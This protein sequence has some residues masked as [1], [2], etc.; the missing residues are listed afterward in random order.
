M[1]QY[2]KGTSSPTPLP[3]NQVPVA[4]A[5]ADQSIA[6]PAS[7]VTLNGLG[8]DADGS[9]VSY[10]WTKQAGPTS[11]TLSN[12]S[13]PN[14]KVNNLVHGTYTFRLTVKDNSGNTGYDEVNIVVK[15]SAVTIPPPSTTSKKIR[16]N[17][18]GGANPYN[19]T[20][21]NNW[22]VGI[23]K[24][25]VSQA[26][27]YDDGS[28]SVVKATL[29]QSTGIG[30]NSSSIPAGMA[31]S[32]VLRYTSYSTVAR[33]LKLSGFSTSKR[34]DIELFASRNS[35]SGNRTVFAV[36]KAKDTVSTYNNSIEK[37][38]LANLGPDANGQIVININRL[39]T[40]TY[41][42]GFI[43]TERENAT[44]TTEASQ[45]I[46]SAIET[47]VSLNVFPN[48]VEDR[49]VVQV[50]NSFIGLMNVEIVDLKGVVIKTFSLSKSSEGPTQAYLSLAGL[51]KG[52]YI[53]NVRMSQWS[54]SKIIFKQ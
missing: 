40:Y 43:I 39:Q 8:T 49:L 15:P 17:I 14:P 30:D 23:G 33:T 52:E 34:Y 22:N 26:F 2:S 11:F 7:S 25:I 10:T 35:S 27:K 13:I 3:V 1:L 12:A 45:R 32:E 36:S 4:K 46:I 42:N 53:V 28:A 44:T 50:K 41:L 18:F 5:G 6:L 24:A 51:Q 38:F 20:Q 19:N 9:I 47:P 37:A 16:V 48:P 29:S 54:E 31:P 21:W